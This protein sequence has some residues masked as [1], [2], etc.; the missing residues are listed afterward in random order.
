MGSPRAR[1]MGWSH[2]LFLTVVAAPA[3]TQAYPRPRLAGDADTLDPRSYWAWSNREDVNWQRTIEAR[4]WAWRLAPD[5]TDYLFGVWN[6]LWFRRAW[7]WRQQYVEGV[8]SVLRSRE[9]RQLD[10]L[11]R[12]IELQNPFPYLDGPCVWPRGIEEFYDRNPAGV[13]L[14]FFD[15]NCLEQAA[16]FFGRALQREPGALWMRMYRARSLINRRQ[17]RSG[18]ADLQVVLDSLRARDEEY[19]SRVYQSKAFF[20]YMVGVAL[21]RA[22]DL[23][24][25]RAAYGRAL[26]ED[27][28]FWP[29]HARLAD[30]AAA[31]NNLSEAA[32]EYEMAVGIRGDD[33]V[34]RF[35]YGV[36]LLRANRLPEAEAQ[37]REAVRLEPWWMEPY[38]QLADCLERQGNTA[39]AIEMYRAYADRV[40]DRLSSRRDTA[41]A[42]VAALT[43]GP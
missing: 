22:Q 39:E 7:Q 35:R 2:L 20:E 8:P 10:S 26:A 34:L 41:L 28:A 42:R 3:A 19:F 4:Y 38:G 43:G 6:A 25:A 18:V 21:Q 1:H 11:I 24:G 16:D 40:P 14:E 30:V 5:Q 32:A 15:R 17:Y 23:P 27:L 33:G 29:A 9:A 36:V 13:A 31:Q 37:L 12:D